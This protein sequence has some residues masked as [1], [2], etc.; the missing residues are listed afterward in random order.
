MVKKKTLVERGKFKSEITTAL[1]KNANIREMLLGDTTGMNS[2]EIRANFKQYVKSHLF[3]DDTINEAK[4][5]IFYDV[6]F[7]TLQE[8]IKSCRVVMYLICSRD[9]L[10]DYSKE[11]YYGDRIDILSQMVED[12]LINDEEVANSFGIGR[13]KL[14]SVDIYNANRFYGCILKFDVPAFR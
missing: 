13:L 14:D 9:I 8:Q 3:I 5:F 11:G 12:T 1:Y 4:T 10:E 6:I 7:P 2:S